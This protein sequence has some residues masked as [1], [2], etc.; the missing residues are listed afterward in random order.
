[1]TRLSRPREGD[2]ASEQDNP[3]FRGPA[4][5]CSRAT[6][7]RLSDLCDQW[8][9]CRSALLAGSGLTWKAGRGLTSRESGELQILIAAQAQTECGRTGAADGLRRPSPA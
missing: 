3:E 8:L 5:L 7:T 9:P 6:L 4:T 1:M 2:G